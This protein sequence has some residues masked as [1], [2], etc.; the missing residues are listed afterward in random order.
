MRRIPWRP[1]ARIMAVVITLFVAALGLSNAAA[2]N[3]ATANTATVQHIAVP[4]YFNPN[5]SPGSTFWTQLDQSTPAVGIAVANPDSGPGSAFD[6]GYAN[7]VQA[8]TNSGVQVI[9][10]VD[11]G[12]FGTTGRTTRDG[13]TTTAAWTAQAQAD[14]DNWYS[15]YGG[16]GLAGIFFD[17]GL[18]DCGT[19]NAHVSLYEAINTFTK[20][21]HSGALTVDNPGVAADQCYADAADVLVM[22]EG[23]Y[24]DY[25]TWTAPAWELSSTDPDKFWHLIYNTPTQANMENAV[26]LSKQRNAGYLYVTDDNL[27]NPWDTLPTGTYWSDELSQSAADGGGGG[28]GG[29]CTPIAGSGDITSYSACMTATTETFTATFNVAASFHH[30]FIDTDNNQSTGFQLPAPSTSA[31]GA[32]YMI[33]NNTLYQS[34]SSGW[35]WTPVAGV[36]PNMTQN[37]N[38]YTWTVPLSALNNPATTQQAEFNGNTFYTDP[39]TFAQS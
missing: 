13:Q 38:T 9:G 10:Y 16:Y 36:S 11:T 14:V 6:Q 37:G 34:L 23:T 27:P 8:A 12:Y 17:D 32:D 1:R 31:L 35:S 25:T 4:A 7:A 5:G 30:V 21:N 39:V 2:A 15:W 28:G 20:Q 18:A 24:A 26:S 33:E 29:S 3:T 19:D 22:F